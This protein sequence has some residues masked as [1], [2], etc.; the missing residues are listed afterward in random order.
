MAL[1]AAREVAGLT[2]RQLAE[3]VSMSP[4]TISKYE[5][6]KRMPGT[7]E[8]LSYEHSVLP[9][10]LQSEGY[11]RAILSHDRYSP[12]DLEQRVNDP[13]PTG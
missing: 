2:V 10:L 8:L 9:G 7:T 6:G 5:T 3:A 1:A 13:P 4:A 11:A 12:L